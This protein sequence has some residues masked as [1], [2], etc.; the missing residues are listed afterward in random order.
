M[1]KLRLTL[2]M[3]MQQSLSCML[4]VH[5]IMLRNTPKNNYPFIRLRQALPP[6][7][8]VTLRLDKMGLTEDK[9][10]SEYSYYFNEGRFSK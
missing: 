10:K 9:T 7:K 5:R 8:F 6:Y 1:M 2:T 3:T 4:V